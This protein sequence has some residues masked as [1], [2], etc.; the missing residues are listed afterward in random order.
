MKS[1]FAS[2]KYEDKAWKEKVTEW[3]LEGRLGYN[4]RIT[5]EDKD[6]RQDGERAIRQHLSPKVEG[7]SEVIVLVGKD[8]HNSS[9]VDYELRNAKSAGKRIIPVRIPNTTGAAPILIRNEEII[10]FTPEA[11]R[12]AISK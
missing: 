4:V 7:A 2:Y 12:D 11:I 9:G 10:A 3:A 1:V 6:V 5:G 8:T